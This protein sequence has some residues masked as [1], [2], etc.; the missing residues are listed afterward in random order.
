[1]TSRRCG[2]SRLLTRWQRLWRGF[3]L[4]ETV[5]ERALFLQPLDLPGEALDFCL[6]RAQAA[7]GTIAAAKLP[8][9]LESRR[10]RAADLG[11]EDDR[12]QRNHQRHEK[13]DEYK[14]HHRVT[15]LEPAL[16]RWGARMQPGISS[17]PATGD[18]APIRGG[19]I[20]RNRHRLRDGD[21]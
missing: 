19:R 20:E 5:Q 1:Q 11:I 13:H 8:V 3:L 17:L 16:T 7:A 14:H 6:E 12:G 15:I 9:P 4:E 21:G 2:R 18:A 10:Q